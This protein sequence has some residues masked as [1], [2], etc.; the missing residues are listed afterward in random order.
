MEQQLLC[1]EE[2][3]RKLKTPEET[4]SVDSPA[5]IVWLTWCCFLT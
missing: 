3:N 2:Q 5:Q 4:P 1:G